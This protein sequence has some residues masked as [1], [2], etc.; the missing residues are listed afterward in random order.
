ML[1]LKYAALIAATLVSNVCSA[2]V[3]AAELER[4]GGKIAP[5]VVIMSMFSYEQD[6]WYGISDFNVLEQNITV[7]GLSPEYRDVHC[8]KNG[9]VCQLTLGEAG[10]VLQ[11][12]FFRSYKS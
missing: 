4:R 1:S 10:R 3:H 6:V 2:S 12:T 11:H 8:T 5:K 7:P 9:D